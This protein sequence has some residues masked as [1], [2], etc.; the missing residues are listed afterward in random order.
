MKCIFDKSITFVIKNPRSIFP[1]I[2]QE[3]STLR[4]A[5]E[6]FCVYKWE[7]SENNN[8]QAITYYILL[9]VPHGNEN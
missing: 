1:D 4:T 8:F 3:N 2:E 5:L 9:V 7:A 6:F